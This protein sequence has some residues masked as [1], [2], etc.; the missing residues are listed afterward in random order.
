MRLDQHVAGLHLPIGMNGD[1]G[2][3]HQMEPALSG[4]PP[5]VALE[6]AP[7]RRLCVFELRVILRTEVDVVHVRDEDALNADRLLRLHG[8]YQAFADLYRLELTSRGTR[9]RALHQPLD[10]PFEAGYQIHAPL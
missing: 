8:S 7:H 1:F 9:K 4:R 5:Q 6:I 3:A 10:E 2:P